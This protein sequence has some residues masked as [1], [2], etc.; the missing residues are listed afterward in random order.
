MPRC[1]VETC[2]HSYIARSSWDFPYAVHSSG[3]YCAG[4]CLGINSCSRST[5]RISSSSQHALPLAT[6]YHRDIFLKNKPHSFIKMTMNTIDNWF[7]RHSTQLVEFSWFIIDN[8]ASS[9]Q[10]QWRWEEKSF[11]QQRISLE[12][13]PSILRS[14]RRNADM[15]T[16]EPITTT[17]IT[18]HR[19]ANIGNT[20]TTRRPH[21]ILLPRPRYLPPAAAAPFPPPPNEEELP[22]ILNTRAAKSWATAIE[23][24]DYWGRAPL[25]EF[26]RRS[27][28]TDTTLSRL[29][30]SEVGDKTSE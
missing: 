11:A 27:T 22:P 16:S 15:I 14:G 23:S 2:G 26:S 1:W 3:W 12:V 7:C 25:E 17:G 24:R 6:F 30:C 4:L 19:R 5:A 9:A 20:I 18:P 8:Y 29:I 28:R 13:L 10:E 21:P